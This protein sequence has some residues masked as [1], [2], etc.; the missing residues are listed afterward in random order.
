M[1]SSKN[2]KGGFHLVKDKNPDG[3]FKP[4]IV[5]GAGV[6]VV[7]N[8]GNKNCV[9][10][11]KPR[12][13]TK[14]YD[15]PGGKAFGATGQ[16][17]IDLEKSDPLDVEGD[18][19]IASDPKNTVYK[20]AAKELNEEMAN[21]IKIEENDIETIL[22][23]NGH[24][25]K[26]KQK[27]L[28]VKDFFSKLV[29]TK[30][31]QKEFQEQL[32]TLML[33]PPKFINDVYRL[34]AIRVDGINKDTFLQNAKKLEG[35][36]GYNEMDGITMIPFENLKNIKQTKKNNLQ[37]K[38]IDGN[39]IHLH[40]RDFTMFRTNQIEAF[41]F[42]NKAMNNP[43]TT[44]D[45]SKMTPTTSLQGTTMYTLSQ[46]TTTGATTGTTT[47][48]TGTTTG[49]TATTTTGAT[50]TTGTSGIKT[51][52]DL[53]GLT[54]QKNKAWLN[55]NLPFYQK[56][57]A[58]KCWKDPVFLVLF[59]M[60][61]KIIS[62]AEIVGDATNEVRKSIDKAIGVYAAIGADAG[63]PII[64]VNNRSLFFST[65]LPSM[66]ATNPEQQSYTDHLQVAKNAFRLFGI[67]GELDV[68]TEISTQTTSK[69]VIIENVSNITTIQQEVTNA[70]NVRYVLFG[71]I[72]NSNVG[73]T[74]DVYS[75]HPCKY[76]KNNTFEWYVWKS[77]TTTDV[78]D[79]QLFSGGLNQLAGRNGLL[80]YVKQ[81]HF[82]SGYYD[83]MLDTSTLGISQTSS[84]IVDEYDRSRAMGRDV[85][86]FT[87]QRKQNLITTLA[88][89]D[90]PNY[91]IGTYSKVKLQDCT[92][93]CD[94][95]RYFSPT[96]ETR[97]VLR[98]DITSTITF[99]SRELAK[100]QVKIWKAIPIELH[101][102]QKGSLW[103]LRN[104]TSNKVVGVGAYLKI[105]DGNE[106]IQLR[107]PK[108]VNKQGYEKVWIERV[109]AFV[110]Q[111]L[112]I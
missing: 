5:S 12:T 78:K 68:V 14:R 71:M 96:L 70:N 29:K 85:A 72:L 57:E 16:F 92:A 79:G 40:P 48:T 89:K 4:T 110:I 23:T 31:Q 100:N 38:D 49:T 54:L 103:L 13:K 95:L 82:K 33:K 101:T 62:H 53:Q 97:N 108:A 63:C 24:I 26:M 74:V 90:P 28:N 93:D 86:P 10:V 30:K 59:N 76:W 47:A 34:F 1:K 80:F 32:R 55:C 25:D 67:S 75:L 41:Q 20:T 56:F 73:N 61:W 91:G 43:K 111:G 69:R 7:G 22:E 8:Y 84:R 99:H 77:M 58:N 51:Q 87:P 27:N 66:Q 104:T 45:L 39:E 52:I 2:Q 112:V 60:L 21:L 19:S 50:A 81:D 17:L 64:K 3:T 11:V 102:L 98:E 106:W 83:S 42:L 9:V 107:S 6:F 105:S 88:K 37:V 35:V 65:F 36:K 15:V 94:V 46:R 109:G 18:K 44:W